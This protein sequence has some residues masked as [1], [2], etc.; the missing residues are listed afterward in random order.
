VTIHL[1]RGPTE[2]A[3]LIDERRKVEHLVAAAGGLP[4][5]VIDDDDEAAE[6]LRGSEHGGLPDGALVAL[7]VAHDDEGAVGFF[8]ET[9][10]ER[11]A[12][13]DRQ[14]VTERAGGQFDAGGAVGR[15]LFGEFAAVLA[16]GIEPALGE[17][18][19][20]GQ[21][22]VERGGRVAFAQDE[23]V[24]LEVGGL[25]RVDAERAPIGGHQNVDTRKRG[26]EVGR[27]GVVGELNDLVAEIA[28]D[29]FERRNV[30][31]ERGR[32]RMGG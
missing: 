7:A 16:E 11:E 10:R 5:V 24:T 21:G 27:A 25:R 32:G 18:V 12:D 17:K 8:R 14:S 26:A 28:G 22:G 6:T 9:G 29:F 30:G 23:A 4:F 3:P 15:G 20:R 31:T 2:G 1:A 19:A 13:A